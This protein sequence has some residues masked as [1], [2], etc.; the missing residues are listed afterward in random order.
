MHRTGKS[1][2]TRAVCLLSLAV[3]AT[4]TVAA[5]EP[6]KE[7]DILYVLGVAVS[8]GLG[9]FGLNEADLVVVLDGIKD[10]VTGEASHVNPRDYMGQI[11]A[12]QREREAAVA[13]AE[14]EMSIKFVEAAAKQAGA[15]Q[16][17]SG[18]VLTTLSEGS[19]ESPKPTDTVRVHYHGTLRNG[20]VFDS[21]VERNQ[22]ATFPLNR[23]IAC[24]TEGVGMM[25]VG[26]KSK[27]VCPSD[28]AYGDRGRPPGIPGGAALVF[29][30]E[31]LEVVTSP[32]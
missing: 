14:K 10:G 30:V 28:I 2:L 5:E 13:A 18:L 26:G 24:W 3:I 9:A 20:T 21:S 27:L 11:Q 15:K 31:L 12:L 16:F 23:V 7:D 4:Q 17:D 25:K 29:D 8:Q 32:Q 19:G 6:K 22:P 1:T